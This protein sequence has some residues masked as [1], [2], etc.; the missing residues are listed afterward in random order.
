MLDRLQAAF[1]REQRFTADASHELRTPLAAIKGSIGVT[2][3]R[4]RTPKEYEKTLQEIEQLEQEEMGERWLS[5]DVGLS[6]LLEVLLEQLQPLA[7]KKKI[8]ISSEIQGELFIQ[9]NPDYLTSLFLNLLDNAIK[10]T[11]N[12][13]RLTVKT[14][15][16]Y[17]QIQVAITNTGGGIDPEHLPHLFERF[18]RAQSGR[19]WS[20]GGAGLGLAIAHEIA[21][22]HGGSITV[23]SQPNQA[24]TF[25]VS[26]P[27]HLR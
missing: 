10:Y 24:T 15:K 12:N 23:E 22:L 6:S 18:Y 11:P 25:T 8:T 16:K 2:L 7:E 4:R 5:G 21:R 17:A 3:S 1:E 13:G 9:G 27:Q 26:F 20:T 14:R 19:S